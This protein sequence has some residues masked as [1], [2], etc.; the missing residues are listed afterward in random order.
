MLQLVNSGDMYFFNSRVRDGEVMRGALSGGIL[1][2]NVAY[3][4]G[5][6]WGF[7]TTELMETLV[8]EAA[9][10]IGHNER[11]AQLVVRQNGGCIIW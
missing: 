1:G 6:V 11:Q 7:G 9:H 2:L 5:N 4:Y 10:N 8:H 3:T